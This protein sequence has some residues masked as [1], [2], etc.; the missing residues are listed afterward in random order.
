MAKLIILR[1]NS[2]SGKTTVARILQKKIGHNTLIISQDVVRREM[3]WVKDG[4]DNRAI[5][6]LQQLLLYGKE[7][8]EAV[9]LEGIL[10]SAWYQPLFELAKEEFQEE[11]YAYYYDLPF[12]ETLIRHRT[13]KKQEEFGEE[14][15][16][17]WWIEKDFLK[18]ISEKIFTASIGAEEAAEQIL[19]D[20]YSIPNREK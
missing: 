5:P 9:I 10:Y 11:I 7:R 2:G 13:R 8:C 6:L 14:A 19:Q 18:L 1:G 16:R 3:L 17:R 20:I 15:M 4:P 12:E